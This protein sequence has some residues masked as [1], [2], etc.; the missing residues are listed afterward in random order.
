MQQ[1]SIWPVNN[2]PYEVPFGYFLG[3]LT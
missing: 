2:N 1:E 3:D